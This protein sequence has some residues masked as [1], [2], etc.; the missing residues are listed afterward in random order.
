[1]KILDV[2]GTGGVSETSGSTE[3]STESHEAFTRRGAMSRTGSEDREVRRARRR[4]ALAV[5]LGVFGVA[6]GVV[7]ATPEE[8]FWINDCGNKALVAKRLL[9]TRY[10]DLAF[11]PPA[12]AV[13]P[14]ARAFPIAAPFAVER[15]GGIVSVY[16]PAYAALSAPFLAV[17]GPN[18][19][20]IP[21]AAGLAA[22]AGA[23]VLWL[24][25]AV[26][27]GWAM[28]AGGALALAT[29]LFFYGVTVWEHS[30]TV[31]ACLLATLL[32]ARDTR[33]RVVAAGF[34]LAAACWLR[35]EVALMGVAVA[36]VTAVRA[37]GPAPS[38]WLAVGA[39][40]P[41]LG[42]FAFNAQLYGSPLGAHFAAS[43]AAGAA[44]VGMP[45]GEIGAV[46]V[47]FSLLAGVASDARERGLLGVAALALPAFGWFM[48]RR[49]RAQPAVLALT[50]GAAL[51]AWAFGCWQMATAERPLA[52]LVRYNGLLLQMPMS[53]LAGLGAAVVWKRPEF[54]P[55]RLGVASGALFAGFVLVAGAIFGSG[56]GVQEGFGVHWGPRVLLPAFPALVALALAAVWSGGRLVGHG[57]ARLVRVAAAAL[58]AAGVVSSAYATWFL[59]EQKSDAQNFQQ[60][61]RELPARYVVVTHPLLAQHVSGLW[62]E[63]PMLLATDPAS[64]AR[65]V[66]G[67][68]RSGVHEFQF[69]APAGAMTSSELS[70]ANC[71]TVE[72]TRGAR[73]HYFDF[74]IQQCRFA[75][76]A[77]SRRGRS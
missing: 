33:A 26:G 18:G 55:L 2:D 43:G 64:L 19:L 75:A 74:D 32:L 1:M 39:T 50:A 49:G 67:L 44:G 59:A 14:E 30:L 58:V 5:A 37:R 9:E 7:L 77:R 66:S 40:L 24:V 35:E 15:P 10:R 48:A 53:A 61:L 25:P 21:A 38:L 31:A 52:Q 41:A 47:V 20:R 54:A 29:P 27:R 45:A 3:A 73:L 57:G 72:K 4:C 6:V 28:L 56:Y 63:R 22:C 68:Q 8:G 51:A 70:G 36:L 42:L 17:F 71:R 13:D 76:R 23:M 46:Q 65:V 11:D 12:L 69:V 34:V 62:D 60:V 16:P